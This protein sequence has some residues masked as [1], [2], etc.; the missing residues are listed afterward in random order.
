MSAY[1]RATAVKLH[2]PKE[3]KVP[4]VNFLTRGDQGE[5]KATFDHLL[6]HLNRG[7]VI[8]WEQGDD[9]MKQLVQLKQEIG[10]VRLLPLGNTAEGA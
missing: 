3:R 4:T 2:A 1:I 8:D 5:L 7:N 6:T 9:L 10:D